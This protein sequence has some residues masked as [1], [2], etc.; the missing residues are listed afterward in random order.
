M[1]I[2]LFLFVIYS[3]VM[4]DARNDTEYIGLRNILLLAFCIQLFVPISTVAMRM[5]YYFLT[6]LPISIPE[7][8]RHSKI[9]MRQI[10]SF[11]EIIM[12]VFLFVYYIRDTYVSAD[13]LEM[14]P[15]LPFW[16]YNGG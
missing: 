6:I 16:Q 3:F 10:V 1:L 14:Y 7:I 9:K 13:I 11:A 4:V 8:A 2:L 15:Y 5:N 12:C